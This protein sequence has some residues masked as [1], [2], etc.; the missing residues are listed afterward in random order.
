MPRLLPWVLLFFLISHQCIAQSFDEKN[1]IHYTTLNGL[2]DNYI[3]GL[4][5][6]EYGY[7]WISTDNG[8]NRFDGREL[9]R[10]YQKP[11]EEGLITNKLKNVKT[12]GNE[13]F[14]YSEKGAQWIN[15]AKNRFITL[16]VSENK[17]GSSI[18]NIVAEALTTK[19]KI[20]FA[21]TYTGAYA[22]DST[23]KLIF[24]Y[25]H[26]PKTGNISGSRYGRSVACLDQYRVLH[27]D[28]DFNMSVYDTRNNSFLPIDDYKNTLP[29]LYSLKGS[30]NISGGI[31]NKLIFLNYFTSEIS[32]Y[33]AGKDIIY[34][35]HPLPGSLRRNIGWA[36]HWLMINDS[37]GIIYGG[38]KGI[39]KTHVNLKTFQVSYDSLPL[40]RKYTFT[41]AFLDREHRLWLGTESGLFRQNLKQTILHSIKFPAEKRSPDDYTIPFTNFLRTSDL[42]YVGSYSYSPILVLD[43]KS[44]KVKKQISFSTLSRSC[45]E[46]WQ[47]IRY[48]RD[49][50]W[51]ATQDGLIW[52]DAL[53]GHFNRVIIAGTD[54]LTQHNAITLLYKDSKGM[55]WM[56]MGWGKG[57]VMYDPLNNVTKRFAIS[58]TQ[59]YLPL[60]VVNFVT[61]DKQ[62]NIWFAE[63]GLTRWN[64]QKQ[65]FDT[66]ITSYYGFNK[67]NTVIT[68]LSTDENG[69]LVFCNENNG[70]LIYNPSNF[71]YKQITSS[72]GLEENAAYS[73]RSFNNYLWIVTHNNIT[74]ISKTNNV[75]ISYSYADS[76]PMAPFNVVYHDELS[77]RMLF[78]YDNEIIWTNDSIGRNNDRPI[79]FYIDAVYI[80]DYTIFFFP[81]QNIELNHLQN[82]ITIHYSALNFDDAESNRYAYRIN[83]KEWVPLGT[84]N[85]IHFSNLSPGRYEVEIKYY[86]AS[87]LKSEA[88]RKIT[89]IVLAP[90]WKRWWFFAI[91]AVIIIMGIYL[92]YR[93]RISE[94]R[95]KARID[96]QMA[97][98][99]IKA[100]HAQMNPHFIFNCL[101]SIREMILNNE[102]Q[103]A[104]HYLSKF[105][106]LI[107]ITLNQS[108]NPFISL[109]N[110]IDYLQRYLEMEKIRK[111]NFSYTIQVDKTIQPAYIF[112]P[113]M[114][115]QPFIEN[116]IWHS[117][118]Q[119]SEPLQININ[120]FEKNGQMLCIVEDNGVGIET[121]LKN[122]KE[123]VADYSSVGIANVK[124]RI[125]VLNEKYNLNCSVNIEDKSK[126]PSYQHGT[127][128]TLYLSLKTHNLQ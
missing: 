60:R 44:Y 38:I 126:Q 20:T 68:S 71:S 49:T 62:G 90:F 120:F 11:G 3:T 76:L 63:K 108:L 50:L 10:I 21:S 6:D 109:K 96:R 117:N 128:V 37:T 99:E 87:N 26:I 84:E 46:I 67:N 61:E 48:N 14:I 98:F 82:D 12:V 118:P 79:S 33:D 75:M 106:Y 5:Q 124:Q 81:S 35:Q 92:F 4:A 88:I 125:Q 114:L 78:G 56:Q 25:D 119:Q 40:F 111:T 97:E 65:Q 83:Q 69:N 30:M 54:S 42:L 122:K 58:D 31:E 64:R 57:V 94:I 47:I 22:F 52:Y 123:P 101:N 28:M 110:T 70:V 15:T 16:T 103:Q 89:F 85:S 55:I 34:K 116:A 39:I 36:S 100:L 53:S 45:N 1:F 104:S 112:L 27:L 127:I 59:N 41:A 73:A 2:S 18:Q 8:L 77:S 115:I 74:A 121:S 66:L 91:V 107:R 43:G 105:A 9:K 51:F 29:G 80:P 93:N 102:N 113:P 19:N 17:H 32:I 72:D 13:L 95:Q 23:G 86:A 7:I 24:R